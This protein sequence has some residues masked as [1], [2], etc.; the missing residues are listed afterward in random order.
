M[1][2]VLK[3]SEKGRCF[4]TR[5]Q[6][7]QRSNWLAARQQCKDII[8]LKRHLMKNWA[9]LI[10]VQKC[11]KRTKCSRNYMC[12]FFQLFIFMISSI[13]TG[14]TFYFNVV[15][16]NSFNLIFEADLLRDSINK[17]FLRVEIKLFASPALHQHTPIIPPLKLMHAS[18]EL[19]SMQDSNTI[20]K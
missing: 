9:V 13:C 18:D 5:N 12:S 19:Y 10:K 16:S 2:H 8:S 15:I 20:I 3:F 1:L 7:Q 4:D 14:F 6:D 17:S 11:V